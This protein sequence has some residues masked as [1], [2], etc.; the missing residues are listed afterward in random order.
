MSGATI[1]GVVG[2]IT[3]AYY[4]AAAINGYTVTR[5]DGRWHLV[6]TVVM[7]DAYK[8][9]QRPLFFVAPHAQGEFRWPILSIEHD[10]DV[11]P[12]Q[13]RATLGPPQD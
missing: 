1:T 9:S 5:A 11:G 3:W 2:Q 13:L 10:P 8:L 12:N 7:T 4:T 6:G